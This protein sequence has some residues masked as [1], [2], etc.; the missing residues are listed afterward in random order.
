MNQYIVSIEIENA[1]YSM[2]KGEMKMRHAN[3]SEVMK[4]D[5]QLV[6]FDLGA[7]FCA[8]HEWGIKG[9]RRAFQLND[10]KIGIDKRMIT[11]IPKALVYK[12]MTYENM[13]CHLLVLI[14][15]C[16]DEDDVN[17]AKDDLRR[18][19]LYSYGLENSGIVTAWDEKSF[20]ILVTDKYKN[21]L[22]ELY[23]AFQSLD[24]AIGIA[25]SEAFRNGGL[26]FCI[27]SK[28]PEETIQSIKDADLDY[29]ALQE[30]VEKTKIKDILAKAGKKYFA[31]SPRWK[32][33][34]KKEAI[35]W[36]NP[37]DQQNNN[38]GWYTVQDLKDWAKGKGKI[39]IAV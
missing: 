8:E 31:L 27:K 11:V 21:E 10:D 3:N 1:I 6:G 26:K 38:F 28:L 24:V 13:K 37:W 17:I 16:Y 15:Y 19:E 39:P 35:F 22:K 2:K 7:D 4:I 36:L 23:Q 34:N 33:E 18:W 9:I 5:G 12:D 32:D 20:A 25:P 30:A 14:P 29:I